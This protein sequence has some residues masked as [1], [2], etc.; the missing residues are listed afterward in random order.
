MTLKVALASDPWTW[1]YA[2]IAL[3]FGLI[4]VALIIYVLRSPN[5]EARERPEPAVAASTDAEP[6]GDDE[7]APEEAVEVPAAPAEAPAPRARGQGR[8]R[9]LRDILAG[10]AHRGTDLLARFVVDTHGETVGETLAFEGDLAILKHGETF[11]AVELDDILEQGDDLVADPTVD[12]DAAR[13]AGE[14]WRAE[15]ENRMEYDDDGMPVVD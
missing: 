3:I 10:E 11:L 9:S 8:A 1:A 7:E 2:A 5:D 4:L 15:Q 14:A 12:W 13:S 6:D